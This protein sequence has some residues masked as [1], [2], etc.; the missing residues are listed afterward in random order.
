MFNLPKFGDGV[1]LHRI[2]AFAEDH[3]GAQHDARRAFSAL[4]G[5]F[6]WSPIVIVGSKGKGSTARLTAALLQ[7]QGRRVGCFTSP[8]LYDVRERFRIGEELIPR[9]DFERCLARVLD[10]ND[11]RPAG[12]RMGAFEALFLVGLLWFR[13][14]ACDIVVWEAGIGGRYDPVRTLGARIGGLTSVELEHTELLGPTRELIAYDKL[15]A[16]APEGEAIVSRCVPEELWPRMTG[17]AAVKGLR[18][19][20][21]GRSAPEVRDIVCRPEGTDLTLVHGRGTDM[22][23][24]RLG[25]VGRH[26]VD[27]LATALVLA[28]RA[29]PIPINPDAPLT[30]I[31]SE[32]LAQLHI[33]GRMER[34]SRD[35]DLWIDVAHTP[36][37]VAAAA[38]AFLAFT[39]RAR[40]LLLFGASANKNAVGMAQ[41]L[42]ARFDEVILTQPVESGADPHT[43]ADIFRNARVQIETDLETAAGVAR[44][45]AAAQGL[46]VLATGGLFFVA[47]IQTAWAGGDPRRLERL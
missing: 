38:D 39:P 42:A 7:A 32:A 31:E 29:A 10:W 1:G 2:Q 45:R 5:L 19:I 23:R 37:S 46:A 34:V 26:Q 18:L 40:S 28:R 33:D 22:R 24:I 11:R 4:A 9:A 30:D 27:N 35:P 36:E 47:E 3:F 43:F 14:Q 8:H 12:D 13:E 15:D 25:L 41:A 21:A 17:F 6:W 44:T 20:A 16:L